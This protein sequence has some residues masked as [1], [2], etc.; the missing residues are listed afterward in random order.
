MTSSIDFPAVHEHLKPGLRLPIGG[1]VVEVLSPRPVGRTRFC[2]STSQLLTSRYPLLLQSITLLTTMATMLAWQD[3]EIS[4][5]TNGGC[6]T[7][8]LLD[9]LTPISVKTNA[10]ARCRIEGYFGRMHRPPIHRCLSSA[11]NLLAVRV[12]RPKKH[13]LES[14]LNNVGIDNSGTI[15]DLVASH[16]LVCSLH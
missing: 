9:S 14:L 5:H 2:F 16:T 6:S 3:L 13:R 4:E 7:P 15:D 10:V 8:I 11:E 1:D 12:A